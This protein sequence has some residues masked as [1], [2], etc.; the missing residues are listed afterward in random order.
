[1]C[2]LIFVEKALYASIPSGAQHSRILAGFGSLR[3]ARV[4]SGNFVSCVVSELSIC[5]QAEGAQNSRRPTRHATRISW[6]LR[7]ML[8][9]R[10]PS[11]QPRALHEYR[12]YTIRNRISV[13]RRRHAQ[14][15]VNCG[16]VFHCYACHRLCNPYQYGAQQ[17]L[18][19]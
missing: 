9:P 18:Q 19:A 3:I 13:F 16:L 10:G 15:T 11:Q 6:R 8:G 17:F 2:R 4:K 14:V 7:P 12:R 1:M 5:V